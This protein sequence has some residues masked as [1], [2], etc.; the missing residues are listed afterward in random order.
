[1]NKQYISLSVMQGRDATEPLVTSKM[2]HYEK[3]L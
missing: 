2:G 1:M 3:G